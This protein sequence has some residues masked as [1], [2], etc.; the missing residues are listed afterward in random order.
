M[1]RIIAG[2]ARGRRLAVPRGAVTRPTSDRAREGLFS[3]LSTL[4]TLS[5]SSV[6]DLYAGSGALGL[7]AMSRGAAHALLVEADRRAADTLRSNIE[8]VG[9]AAGATAVL[10]PVERLA[11]TVP[12]QVP[13][14]LGPYDI[15]FADPPYRVPDQELSDVLVDLQRMGWLAPHAVLVV[16]RSARAHPWVWPTPLQPIRDRR[17]GEALLWYGRA[18]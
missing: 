3:T 9:V 10:S 2:T 12:S 7:E 17:Y 8:A 13:G 15:V 11:A 6:L 5:G 16:E 1:T 18:P 4:T 14:V